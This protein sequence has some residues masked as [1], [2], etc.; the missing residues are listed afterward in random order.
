[1]SKK[2]FFKVLAAAVATIV[3]FVITAALIRY[4]VFPWLPVH[5]QKNLVW[6]GSAA[7]ATVGIL[8]GF[9]EVT[10]YSFRNLFTSEDQ[11]SQS[12]QQEN[13]TG[14]IILKG[15]MQG[16]IKTGDILQDGSTKVIIERANMHTVASGPS[17]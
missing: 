8:A 7:L 15:D 4:F 9:A 17:P 13:T 10:G 2:S 6:I 1:M 3:L 16:K 11:S 5:W 12:F 14:A